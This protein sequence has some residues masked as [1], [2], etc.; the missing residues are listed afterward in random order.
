MVDRVS[1]AGAYSAILQNLMLAENQQLNA[2]NR[3]SSTKNGNDLKAFATQAETLTAMKSVNTRIVGYQ[4][5]NTQ[6]AAKLQTQDTA[7]TDL[8]NTATSV[9]TSIAN[10]L[11]SGSAETL[12]QEMQDAFATASGDLN[13]QYDGKYLFSGGQV[14]TKAF[15]ATQMTDL[16]SGPALSTFFGNDNF[17]TQAKLDDNT[18]VTTGQLASNIA[19]PLMQVF[20]AIQAYNDNPATGPLSGQ[21]TAAQQAFLTTTMQQVTG[22][23]TGLTTVAA[24]NGLVQSRL[25]DVQKNLTTQQNSLTSM[26]GNIT[27][28]DMAKA[29]TDLSNA[30]LSVQ[31]SAKVLQALQGDSLLNLLK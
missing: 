30:Q 4:A 20:Q 7:L 12:M 15:N 11:A 27:D 25:D 28:A 21:L 23:A 17:Q 3:V 29:A 10:A 1:T 8:S 24:Q 31:A 26:I 14:T 6:I 19:T 22:V 13:T 2:E 16:T 9:R 5:Q 18:T